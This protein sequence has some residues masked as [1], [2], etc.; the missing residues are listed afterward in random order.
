MYPQTSG[1][2]W[3]GSA[4][5]PDY[6]GRVIPFVF[7]GLVVEKFYAATVLGAIASTRYEGEI[8]N[9]GDKVIIRTRPNITVSPYEIGMDL[10]TIV[11]RPSSDT[12]ELLIDKGNVFNLALNDVH[13]VQSDIDLLSMWAEDAA[14]A[15]KIEVDKEVLQYLATDTT[16][17]IDAH[18]RG[19]GAGRIS[20]N[21]NMGDFGLPR[22]IDSQNVIRFI[23][24]CG[25]VLDEQNV[26]ETGRWMVIP[27]WMN[28][29]IKASDLKNAS[30]AGDGTSILRNG[31]LGMIDRFTLYLSNNLQPIGASPSNEYPVLFGVSSALAF[32]AQLTK[33]ETIRSERSFDT[34]LRGLEIHGRKVVNP[35]AIGRAIVEQDGL[36]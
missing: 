4:P 35:V 21:L 8:R 32:A 23:L 11:Q 2:W 14:E 22:S 9:M 13:E 28:T 1:S 33:T 30:L 5:S 16:G 27:A 36:T 20:G 29:L 6:S 34:L 10:N 18:N 12:I 15:M 19:L 17:D 7:S 31:R 3:A 25:Q 24:D 26:P